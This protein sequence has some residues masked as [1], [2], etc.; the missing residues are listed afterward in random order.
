MLGGVFICYRREDSAGF[1]R[2]IYDRLA[3]RLQRDNVFFNVD[4]IEPGV[5]FFEILS[6]RVGKCDAL[7]AVIGKSWISAADKD[8]RR[9]LDDPDDFVR[10]EIEAALE[11]GVR[12]IPVLIDG[13]AMPRASDLPDSLKKL[14]RRQYVEVSHSRFN[15]NVERLTRTLSSILENLRQRDAAQANRRHGQTRNAVLARRLKPNA[16]LG[17]PRRKRKPRSELGN[18]R[19]P[20][21]QSGR[22]RIAL[23]AKWPRPKRCD[24]KSSPPTEERHGDRPISGSHTGMAAVACLSTIARPRGSSSSPLTRE[25]RP[26]RPI[27]GSSMRTG[28]A[29]FRRTIAR[30]RASTSSPP[31]RGAQPDRPISGSSMNTGLGA[32]PRTTARQRGST[33]SPPTREGQPHRSISGDF[34]NMD[35]A[36]RG[37]PVQFAG[38]LHPLR[39]N[40][41]RASRRRRSAPFDRG[42]LS[43]QGLLCR[44]VQE[45]LGRSRRQALSPARGRAAID[46]ARRE[47]GHPHSAVRG[48]AAAFTHL[49]GRAKPLFR[50]LRKGVGN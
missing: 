37:G 19:R 20:K 27:S 17:R 31:T 1:A 28:V 15:S 38:E 32:C 43:L 8:N 18:Q 46:R 4:N 11:R 36:L 21:R 25:T 45:S 7:V 33:S 34:V 16:S 3:Q 39:R 41:R 35:A 30:P 29:A 23:P 44:R 48:G 14:V 9:R 42:A 47:R 13:A 40:A 10:I 2:L 12:V 49:G 22:T 50:L 26:D 5:D 6:E 24:A